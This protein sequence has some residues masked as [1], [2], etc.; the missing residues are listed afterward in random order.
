[1]DEQQVRAAALNAATNCLVPIP[2]GNPKLSVKDSRIESYIN[3]AE[4]FAQ[5]IREGQQHQS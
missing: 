5:Y 3:L 2:S 1:M 4:R